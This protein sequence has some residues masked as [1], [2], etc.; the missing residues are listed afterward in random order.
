[1][2]W[3]YNSGLPFGIRVDA[4]SSDQLGR[5]L[6]IGILHGGSLACLL[7]CF[8]DHLRLLLDENLVG[9]LK[10]VSILAMQVNLLSTLS[11]QGLRWLLSIK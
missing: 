9:F 3:R 1:M 8:D 6:S 10:L 11:V 4:S 7:L 2:S 5:E